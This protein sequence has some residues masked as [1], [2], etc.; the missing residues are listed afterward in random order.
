MF[1]TAA[2]PRVVLA[3]RVTYAGLIGR[4]RVGLAGVHAGDT[5]AAD[6]ILLTSPVFFLGRGRTATGIRAA[7]HRGEVAIVRLLR[8]MPEVLVIR[9]S[10]ALP[11]SRAPIRLAYGA[12]G[13]NPIRAGGEGEAL[14]VWVGGEQR[15][16][17]GAEHRGRARGSSPNTGT[18]ARSRVQSLDRTARHPLGGGELSDRGDPGPQGEPG[19][20]AVGGRTGAPAVV[21]GQEADADAARRRV[22]EPSVV[23]RIVEVGPWFPWR[24]PAAGSTSTSRSPRPP[25]STARPG[26][27][28]RPGTPEPRD[29]GIRPR[30]RRECA[31]PTRRS[32]AA[33]SWRS[34]VRTPRVNRRRTAPRRPPA[35]QDHD[36]GCRTLGPATRAPGFQRARQKRT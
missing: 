25:W 30:P 22:R 4:E 19:H 9:H 29:H 21:M 12:R 15:R 27:S 16:G 26:S 28:R 34:R 2:L 14:N 36:E 35:P 5:S 8:F 10:E 32:A 18:P 23:L 11:S 13:T 33:D 7:R 24:Y 1:G 31:A 20:R 3:F 6:L 17:I